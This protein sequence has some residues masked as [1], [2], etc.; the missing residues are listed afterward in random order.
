MTNDLTTKGGKPPAKKQA[1]AYSDYDDFV[2]DADWLVDFINIDLTETHEKLNRCTEKIA[3]IRAGLREPNADTEQEY[4]NCIENL[5]L[6]KKHML[7]QAEE[8]LKRYRADLDYYDRDELYGE[9]NRHGVRGV[10]RSVITMQ[11]IALL[12]AFNNTNPGNPKVFCKLLVEEILASKPTALALESAR[13][14]FLRPPV[15]KYSPQ[16]SEVH[17]AIAVQDKKWSD[18]FSVLSRCQPADSI[19][20]D[21]HEQLDHTQMLADYTQEAE[22]KKRQ[23]D[24]E[25]PKREAERQERERQHQEQKRIR[26]DEERWRLLK[27]EHRRQERELG[28]EY[29]DQDRIAYLDPETYDEWMRQITLIY[30]KDPFGRRLLKALNQKHANANHKTTNGHAPSTERRLRSAEPSIESEYRKPRTESKHRNKSTEQ[31]APNQ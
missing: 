19:I 31:G 24:L 13:R 20:T 17:A 12:D 8:T 23:H 25:A 18:R 9:E 26:E 10:K 28:E 15:Q 2:V 4:A 21:W 16:I 27:Q 29:R 6:F 22:A 11:M 3:A 30:L 7:P 1:R 5:K 14:A